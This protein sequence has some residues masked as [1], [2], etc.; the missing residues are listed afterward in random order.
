VHTSE[1]RNPVSSNISEKVCEYIIL[2]Y[3]RIPLCKDC[4]KCKH[5]AVVSQHDAQV[6]DN[7]VQS[8]VA[9][10]GLALWPLLRIYG[11]CYRQKVQLSWSVWLRWCP[12]AYIIRW[13]MSCDLELCST[14]F[15]G[16]KLKATAH[17][18]PNKL[19]VCKHLCSVKLRNSLTNA[20]RTINWALP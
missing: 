20:W 13:D 15:S 17:V 5:I 10:E 9:V 1:T 2:R 14:H 4:L 7:A 3:L 19:F 8:I 18:S 16:E 6:G 11:W 12:V